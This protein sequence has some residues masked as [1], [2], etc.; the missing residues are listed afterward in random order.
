[1]DFQC[2]VSGPERGS[3]STPVLMVDN[4]EAIRKPKSSVRIFPS[5]VQKRGFQFHVGTRDTLW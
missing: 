1:M 4:G 5:G 2:H 3:G